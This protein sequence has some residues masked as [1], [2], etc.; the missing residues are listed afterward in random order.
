MTVPSRIPV[1]EQSTRLPKLLENPCRAS[2]NLI[3]AICC[4]T[5]VVPGVTAGLQTSRTRR[6]RPS[7]RRSVDKQPAFITA[8][9]N[10]HR[11]ITTRAG[12]TDL[13]RQ[14]HYRHRHPIIIIIVIVIVIVIVVTVVSI[15]CPCRLG[16]LPARPAPP[17]VPRS[18]IFRNGGP[19]WRA[20]SPWSI[21][22]CLRREADRPEELGKPCPKKLQIC[23]FGDSSRLIG[24]YPKPKK[25]LNP[26]P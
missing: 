20:S 10:R 19:A 14:D 17:A 21:T 12:V 7:R 15:I 3:R 26:K 23:F 5:L 11:H 2:V 8:R 22:G 1:L 4:S 24:I 18:N 25:T 13:E 6:F 9:E 16:F